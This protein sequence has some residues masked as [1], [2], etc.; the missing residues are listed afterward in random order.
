[1]TLDQA[2]ADGLAVVAE[3]LGLVAFDEAVAA[4]DLR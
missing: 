2:F 1:M 4:P 3:G